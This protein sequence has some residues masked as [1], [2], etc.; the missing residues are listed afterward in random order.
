MQL[1]EQ[2]VIKKTHPDW[3]EVDQAAFAAKNLY[4]RAN[5]EM[6]QRFFADGKVLSYSKLYRLFGAAPCGKDA[7]EYQTLPRKVS[8]QV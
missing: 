3:P 5:Y 2:H 1:V 8:Q 6:R 7:P 4:N